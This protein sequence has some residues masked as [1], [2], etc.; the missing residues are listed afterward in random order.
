MRVLFAD[1][2][3]QASTERLEHGGF[4]VR[5]EPGASG[6]ALTEALRAFDP[7]VLVVRST[8]VAAEHI[9]ATSALG[10]VIRA[11][12][13]V[14]TIDL[15]ACSGRGIYVSNCPGKNSDAVAELTI[16]LLVALDRRIPD[17]VRD[18]RAGQWN[19]GAYSKAQG[20]AG[21]TL[22]I[23]GLGGIGA[24]VA[25]RALA[26]DMRVVAWSRSLTPKLAERMG[27]VYAESPRAVAAQADALT[28]HVALGEGTRGI[29][30]AD[31]IDA[32]KPGALVINTAR[33]EV[34]DND[35]LLAAVAQKGLWVGLDTPT[36][37][38][39]FNA[40]AF[41]HPL[42]S[43][44]RVYVTHHIGASTE[45]AQ[46]AVA[47][48]ACR[49]IEG[50]YAT[51]HADNAVNVTKNNASDAVI[52]VR[53]LDR[54]GVLASVLGELRE[55]KVNVLEMENTIFARGEGAVA[56][57][58]AQGPVTP[59]LLARIQSQQYVLSVTGR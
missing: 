21:R 54:V 20:L 28:V 49:I 17:N 46:E 34:V 32:L 50:F 55:A 16:G 30:S 26:F 29:I 35:A 25:R 27:I 15:A 13:G 56:R 58:A 39:S 8:K 44:P 45:Q 12:A 38:P 14:N 42:A 6:D 1:K 18:F 43:N 11:G 4:E 36:D 52:V 53:H 48:E 9:A 2:L 23:V 47:D 33:A 22:G 3:P 40:G 31:V 57:I 7:H 5:S 51:G 59:E 24:A 19:K 10:L 37:E 41:E